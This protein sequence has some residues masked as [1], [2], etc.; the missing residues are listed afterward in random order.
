VKASE[1]KGLG[2]NPSR[3]FDTTHITKEVI[4]MKVYLKPT[5]DYVEFRPEERLAVG[6]CTGCCDPNIPPKVPQPWVGQN[7][8]GL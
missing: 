2:Q 5:I 7:H 6:S 8:P 3:I 1:I 4:N